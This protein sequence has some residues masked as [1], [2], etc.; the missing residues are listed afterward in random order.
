[1][2]DSR[3]LLAICFTAACGGNSS[4][5][6]DPPLGLEA[7]WVTDDCAPWDGA[8][9]TIHLA[10]AVP[11]DVMSVP[12]PSVWVSLY[13]A[14]SE[15]PGRTLTWST[16]E[17]NVGGAMWCVAE[18]ECQAAHQARVRIHHLSANSVALSGSLYLEFPDHTVFEGGFQAVPVEQPQ[19]MCG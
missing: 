14:R 5:I 17:R 19:V 9:T 4:E 2:G 3:A 1:M 6:P 7:S 13:Y 16:D 15:L 11:E 8:A 12:Y 18:G 10:G